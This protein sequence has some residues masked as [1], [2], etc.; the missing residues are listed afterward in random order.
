MQSSRELLEQSEAA[1]AAGGEAVKAITGRSHNA[2]HMVETTWQRQQRQCHVPA[3][4]TWQVLLG[5]AWPACCGLTKPCKPLPPLLQ[6]PEPCLLQT[7]VS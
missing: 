7:L 6:Q 4:C 3:P 5:K 2:K 1:E